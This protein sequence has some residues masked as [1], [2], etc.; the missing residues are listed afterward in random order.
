[1]TPDEILDEMKAEM[2][3][4]KR[5]RTFSGGLLPAFC[6]FFLKLDHP[7]KGYSDWS[8]FVAHYP[9]VTEGANT[10]TVSLPSGKTATIRPHYNE[11]AHY[12]VVENDR[13]DF[14]SAAPHATGQW[15]DYQRWLDALV[16]FTPDVIKDVK[17][18]ALAFTLGHLPEETFDPAEI[19]REPR[20]FEILIEYFEWSAR[21]KG[22]KTGAAF[23]A[24][25]F[26]YI[27]ANSPHLQVE[28]RKVRTGSAR[29]GGIGDI[30]AW[31]GR[32]L[33][34]TAE[35]KH[36]TFHLK[37]VDE[38]SHFIRKATER[39]AH[40]MVVAVDFEEAAAALLREQGVHPITKD[41]ILEEVRNWDPRKQAAA[42]LSFEY[43]IARI[44]KSTGLVARFDK[45][46]EAIN[47]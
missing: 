34:S 26:G 22:E 18:R 27:R 42:V 15:R 36:F 5:P 31:E 8:D 11:V 40:T 1:M 16:T 2:T 20:L 37:H 9:L 30:D 44:E 12:F 25:V 23:Q 47:S 7:A 13:P 39:K 45:F 32:S 46:M 21:A 19:S 43:A 6:S 33:I 10:L 38:I 28:A 14:P 41:A 3:R 29:A 17:E 4:E 35:V 24:L